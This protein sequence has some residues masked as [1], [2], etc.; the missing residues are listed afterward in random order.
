MDTKKCRDCGKD[1][2]LTEFHK[3]RRNADGLQTMC[4]KCLNE[5]RKFLFSKRPKKI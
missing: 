5:H 4:G 1:K 3:Y 2:P